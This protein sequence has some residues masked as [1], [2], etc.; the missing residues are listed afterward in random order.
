MKRT[1]TMAALL[2]TVVSLAAAPSAFATHTPEVHT[3]SAALGPGGSVIA[4][5]TFSCVAGYS[6]SVSTTIRQRAGQEYNTAYDSFYG[7]RGTCETTGPQSYATAPLF[8]PAPFHPGPATVSTSATVCDSFS[9]FSDCGY[10][11][12]VRE[13][14]LAT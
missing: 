13:L 10:G 5:G 9:W 11:Q 12:D 2:A 14:R 7:A 1:A 8:G 6:Y 4:K 3:D